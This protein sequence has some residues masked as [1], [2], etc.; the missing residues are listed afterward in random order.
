M[1]E[2]IDNFKRDVDAAFQTA[3]DA[4][5]NIQADEAKLA[6]DLA[7]FIKSGPAVSGEDLEKLTVLRNRAVAMADKTKSIA[8]SIPDPPAIPPGV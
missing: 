8:D 2:V 5:A 4:L 7:D 1:S 6:K 3:D